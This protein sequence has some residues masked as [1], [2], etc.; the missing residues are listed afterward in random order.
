MLT[1][2]ETE[3][4]HLEQRWLWEEGQAD[5]LGKDAFEKTGQILRLEACFVWQDTVAIVLYSHVHAYVCYVCSVG[6]SNS[7]FIFIKLE[8]S[9]SFRC[10]N[11]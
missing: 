1:A 11:K 10:K 8:S 4:D 6:H 7:F 3:E 9:L 2:V 5:Y